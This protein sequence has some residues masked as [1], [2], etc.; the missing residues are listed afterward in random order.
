ME[1]FFLDS[2]PISQSEFDLIR[3]Y[4]QQNYGIRLHDE[5]K[6]FVC[7]RLN[8][9]LNSRGIKSYQEYYKKLINDKTGE[10]KKEFI[11]RVTTNHTFFMRETAHFDFLRDAVAPWA[12]ANSPDRDIRVWCA[13]C[14]SGE[15]AYT[16]QFVLTDFFGSD[17]N[18]DLLATDISV[19]ALNKAHNG[20]YSKKMT[21]K[22]PLEWR[23]KY[24]KATDDSLEVI[25]D[26]KKKIFFRRINLID[27]SFNFAKKFH[28]IFCRNVMIYFDQKDIKRLAEKFYES[29]EEDGYLF[30][31]HSESL[32][33]LGT[34]YKYISPAIYQKS[35]N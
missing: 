22:L 4:L 28:A 34:P 30:I 18:T 33:N 27:D 35:N 19:T 16:L 13:G 1:A 6:H 2:I 5:K 7:A 11:N 31:G 15:E 17:Y 3:T 26:I 24:F 25:D 8:A 20:V 23:K 10:I 29:T 21:E 32:N 12:K 9:V 14:S